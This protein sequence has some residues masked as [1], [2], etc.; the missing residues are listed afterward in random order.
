MLEPETFKEFLKASLKS[1]NLEYFT[2]SLLSVFGILVEEFP[3]LEKYTLNVGNYFV[4]FMS[5]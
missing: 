2:E 3:L 4:F 1:D 5:L